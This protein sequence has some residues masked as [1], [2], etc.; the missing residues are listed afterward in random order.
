M[1]KLVRLPII[2]VVELSKP[3]TPIPV[4]PSHTAINFERIIEIIILK[5]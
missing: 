2:P 4:G 5:T 1:P 3:K